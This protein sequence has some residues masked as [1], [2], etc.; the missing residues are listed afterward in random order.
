VVAFPASGTP[1]FPQQTPYAVTVTS[2]VPIVV[3]RS[4][5][6]PPGSPSPGW[7]S[8]SATTTVANHWLVPG[9]GVPGAPAITDATVGSLAVANSGPTASVVKVAR[10]GATGPVSTFTVAPG[11]VVVLGPKQVGGL[12]TLT[13]AASQP[14]FVEEDCEPAGTPGVVSSSG[15]PIGP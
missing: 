2:T 14:V 12:A 4:V 1:G 10:L 13:V 3:G 9:P 15:F 6:A 5:D 8:S 7:G 11:R